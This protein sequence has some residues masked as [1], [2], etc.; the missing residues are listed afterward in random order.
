MRE[1]TGK[2]Q[3]CDESSGAGPVEGCGAPRVEAL[4]AS[5][6]SVILR[7]NTRDIPMSATV[8]SADRDNS[9]VHNPKSSELGERI[10]KGDETI[11]TISVIG[12]RSMQ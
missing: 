9:C 5:A 6:L 3:N 1:Y 10:N 4:S 2:Y 7:K 11:E 12:T 8:P